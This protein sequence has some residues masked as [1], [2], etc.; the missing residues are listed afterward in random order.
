[1]KSIIK[2]AATPFLA[3]TIGACTSDTVP[4]F[5]P[6]PL[7]YSEMFGDMTVLLN[8]IDSVSD[9][10]STTLPT[11]G[12]A[13]Y[14]GFTE[15]VTDSTATGLSGVTVVSTNFSSDTVTGNITDIV[16]HNEIR[17]D[18]EVAITNGTFDRLVDPTVFWSMQADLDGVISDDTT[19]YTV[20]GQMN[21]GFFGGSHEYIRGEV[22]GTIADDALSSET[23]SGLVAGDYR[24]RGAY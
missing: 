12:S 23:F 9:T 17:Y 8:E 22:D 4:K 19:N 10:D 18:G 2:F 13:T 14:R 5:V 11:S 15:I 1:M 16:D 3:L 24:R 20:T 21:A 6:A 7:T